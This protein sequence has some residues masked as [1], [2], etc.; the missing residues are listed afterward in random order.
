MIKKYHIPLLGLFF[1][2]ILHCAAQEQFKSGVLAKLDN[3]LVT[4]LGPIV[5][6][7]ITYTSDS[8]KKLHLLLGTLKKSDEPAILITFN[9]F[10][11]DKIPSYGYGSRPDPLLEST[12]LVDN[13]QTRSIL[14]QC[15]YH[16]LKIIQQLGE[17]KHPHLHPIKL[18]TL[19][20]NRRL[21][22]DKPK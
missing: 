11:S 7:L 3:N 21:L 20:L 18:Y 22:Y 6:E 9:T 2:G 10:T 1:W 19:E 13:K 4:P 5:F 17:S 14:P 15:K 12:L 8:Q 16:M